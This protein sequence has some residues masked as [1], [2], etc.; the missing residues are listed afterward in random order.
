[1]LH[2]AGVPVPGPGDVIDAARS[3][4]GWSA[5]TL[6]VAATLPQ[7]AVDLMAEIEQLLPRVSGVVDQ[8]ETLIQRVGALAT[9]ADATIAAASAITA[10]ADV[11]VK[12][13]AVVTAEIEHMVTAAGKVNTQAAAVVA[14]ADVA[15]SDVVAMLAIYEPLAQRAA[16]LAKRFVEELTEEEVRAAISL[17]DLLPDLAKRV[18][19][20]ILPVLTT[21]EGVGP[22][23]HEL[24][25]VLKEV[26]QA[27]HGIPGFKF[28]RR[29]GEEVEAEEHPEDHA[30]EH[31]QEAHLPDGK[32]GGA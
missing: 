16:P 22:D 13:S 1:M 6:G 30:P 20:D 28:F 11:L 27:I 2:V 12:R 24:V 9:K 32:A 31:G 10:S 23:V 26:R 7:R 3:I 17:I 15:T 14:K 4:A 18:E 5:D 29:R 21:L 8:A 25:D 19:R